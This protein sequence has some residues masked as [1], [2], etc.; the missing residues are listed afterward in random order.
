[1]TVRKSENIAI[2]TVKAVDCRCILSGISKHKA[3]NI[4]NKSV[5]EDK[6][7]L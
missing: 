2:L 7:V 6:G 5:L 4:L 1:M 3:V